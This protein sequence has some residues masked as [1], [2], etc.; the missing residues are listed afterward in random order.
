[1]RALLIACLLPITAAAAGGYVRVPG[2]DIKTTLAYEDVRGPVRVPPFEM[3]TRLVT[4]ANLRSCSVTRSGAIACRGSAGPGYLAH[5]PGALQ[6]T[7]RQ[8]AA[9]NRELVRSKS[10]LRSARRAAARMAREHVA[11]ADA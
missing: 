3:M 11:A 9:S 2:G 1:V 7:P 5:W 4:N 8:E 10:L 6:L